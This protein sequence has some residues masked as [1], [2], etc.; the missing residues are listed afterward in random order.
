MYG[1][2]HK[3]EH[4]LSQKWVGSI[5]CFHLLGPI[6]APCPTQ[7]CHSGRGFCP[8][9]AAAWATLRATRAVALANP[10]SNSDC[11]CPTGAD[12]HWPLRLRRL[13]YVM[14]WQQMGVRILPLNY[15]VTNVESSLSS[16]FPLISL[17][18]WRFVRRG[19][20]AAKLLSRA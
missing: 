6:Q 19:A 14:H 12:R 1:G 8:S 13:S 20:L 10:W 18:C 3:V 7:M 5:A 17:Y 16:T 11:S 15:K 4:S 2:R 9:L